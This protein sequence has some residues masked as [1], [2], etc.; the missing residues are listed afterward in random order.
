MLI[1][2]FGSDFSIWSEQL[3]WITAEREDS[4]DLLVVKVELDRIFDDVIFL[5][6]IEI[7]LPKFLISNAER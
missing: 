4:S 5:L 3:G 1:E 2:N 7:S 6:P